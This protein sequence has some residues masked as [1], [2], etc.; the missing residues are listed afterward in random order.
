MRGLASSTG[1]GAAARSR[2]SLCSCSR[3]QRS[4]RG[5]LAARRVAVS[6]SD[7]LTG[8]GLGVLNFGVSW[9][10]LGAIGGAFENRTAVAFGLYSAASLLLIVP[11]GGVAWREQTR[12]RELAGVAAAVAAIVALNP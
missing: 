1:S 4:C 12:A 2:R 7:V 6:P 5:R 9:F 10:M 8:G 3:A 11:I